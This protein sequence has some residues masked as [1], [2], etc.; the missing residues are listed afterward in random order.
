MS[1]AKSV[2]LGFEAKGLPLVCRWWFRGQGST[3]S[4]TTTPFGTQDARRGG[5]P[6]HRATNRISSRL[7]ALPRYVCTLIWSSYSSSCCLNS[8][9]A[10][11][12]W[13]SSL[14]RWS[15]SGVFTVTWSA[16]VTWQVTVTSTSSKRALSP[17]GRSV[18]GLRNKNLH[19]CD[20][21][22]RSQNLIFWG[23]S[24]WCQ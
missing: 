1:I 5:L 4:S 18:F 12:C 23:V 19:H 9:N 2:A 11:S 14:L 3:H 17:C 6:A 22:G 20:K 21:K 10:T 7:A 15:S 13:L 24:G 8:L 16:Q